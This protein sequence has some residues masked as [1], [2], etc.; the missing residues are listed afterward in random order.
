M[1]DLD[2]SQVGGPH[3]LA[4]QAHRLVVIH[5]PTGDRS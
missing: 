2:I 5:S 3:I 1:D 4:G